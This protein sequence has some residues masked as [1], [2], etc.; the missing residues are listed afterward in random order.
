MATQ[1]PTLAWPVQVVLI[2]GALVI[3]VVG[4][5]FAFVFAAFYGCEGSSAL[6]DSPSDSVICTEPLRQLLT[7][8]E[9]TLVL[10]VVIAP[11]GGAVMTS[12]GRGARWLVVGILAAGLAFGSIIALIEGQQSVS[13]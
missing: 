6:Y 13:S 12:R 9:A 1:R 2:A 10:L 4:G 11:L 3:S 7:S 8:V 5:F